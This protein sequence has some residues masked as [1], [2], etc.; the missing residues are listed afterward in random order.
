MNVL[1]SSRNLSRYREIVSVLARHGFGWLLADTNLRGLL[2]LTQRLGRSDD[3]DPRNQAGHLRRALEELGT[4]FIKLGQ[5]LSTRPD[6]L[7]PNY[8]AELSKLQEAAPPV[9]YEQIVAVF[10]AEMGARP[11]DVFTE[12]DPDPLAAASIGQ[13]HAA[14]LANGDDVVVKI[15]RPGVTVQVERDLNIFVE[16]ANLAARYSDQSQNYDLVGLADE[17][18]FNLRCEL[19]YVRE[20]QNADRFREAFAGDPGIYIPTVYWDQTTE[21]VI[22]L[23]Q[24]R[25]LRINDLPAL[26]AEGLDHQEIAANSV[27]LMLEEMFV[28]GFFHADPHPGNL[29]V[30]E[31][32]RI[33]MMDFGML[34]RLDQKLQESLTRLFVALSKGNSERVVDEFLA[35]GITQGEVN[36]A[37]LKRDVDHLIAC[38]IHRTAEELAAAQLFSEITALAR[39]HHLRLPSDL[40]LMARVMAISEGIG[41]QLDPEFQFI[42]FARPYLEQFWLQ[43]RSSRQMGEK[44]IEGIIDLTDFGLDL[45]RHLRRMVTQLEQGRLGAQV[46]IEGVDRYLGEMQRMVNRLSLTV[47]VGALIVGLSQFMHMVTPEGFIEQYASRFFGFSFLAAMVLGVWLLISLIRSGR[48]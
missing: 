12:F 9:P 42:P 10:E 26:K 34:G 13:V 31:D 35:T 38:Y 43:R 24:L 2:P 48:S 22:V 18:A 44:M 16:L 39:R 30:L 17:F 15:Q 14:R 25:G 41:L 11:E 37:V 21:R 1:P 3:V 4:T 23:E 46:E 5:V 36:R 27:R 45:P 29:Y 20:G 32:G 47:L 33:G 19:N 40:M 28:H 6:L 8:I 7:P